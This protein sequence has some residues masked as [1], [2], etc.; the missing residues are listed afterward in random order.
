MK[1]TRR[2]LVSAVLVTFLLSGL[3]CPAPEPVE[4][5]APPPRDG[6][7]VHVSHGLQSPHRVLM[8]LR[9]AELMSKDKD[10]VMYFDIEGIEVLLADA[11]DLEYEP[12]PSSHT[13]LDVLIEKG[14]PVMACPG[15]LKAAGKTTEDVRE[16]VQ[17]AD[18]ETFFSFTD[19]RILTL[20]Y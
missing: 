3:G 11:P 20:D 8:A 19:G 17:I 9:M 15:C 7:F 4:E 6:V 13:Q 5:P 12:F 16:G 1:T 14:V 10:V 18:K 2:F